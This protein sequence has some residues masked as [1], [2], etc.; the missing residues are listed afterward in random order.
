MFNF[1]KYEANPSLNKTLKSS[2]V[3]NVKS[4]VQA[5]AKEYQTFTAEVAVKLLKYC[6]ENNEMFAVHYDKKKPQKKTT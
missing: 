3:V 4:F 6:I 5:Y 1:G 2:L